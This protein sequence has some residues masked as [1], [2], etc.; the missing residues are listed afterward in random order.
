M[1]LSIAPV[2]SQNDISMLQD[3]YAEP[4]PSTDIITFLL[5]S[6]KWAAIPDVLLLLLTDIIN[7]SLIASEYRP[8]DS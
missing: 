7:V 2:S 5:I 8:P 6:A 4:S 3:G 1:S